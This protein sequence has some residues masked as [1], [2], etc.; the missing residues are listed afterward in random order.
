[1]R[2]RFANLGSED[3]VS[4]YGVDNDGDPAR[5]DDSKQY[6]LC[7][8]DPVEAVRC[9]REVC[10]PDCRMSPV[11]DVCDWGCEGVCVWERRVS[12][13]SITQ[14]MSYVR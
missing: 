6:Y 10:Q 5:D 4:A 13:Q 8:L 12:V 2:A 9:V 14:K 7:H 11:C 3:E 1:M